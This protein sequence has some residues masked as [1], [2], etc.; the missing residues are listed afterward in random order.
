M[1]K[2][3]LWDRSVL[4]VE[5]N[6]EDALYQKMAT[7]ERFRLKHLA[8]PKGDAL[9]GKSIARITRANYQEYAHLL[10][11]QTSKLLAAPSNE[12]TDEQRQANLKKLAKMKAEFLERRAQ[13]KAERA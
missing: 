8:N 3:T 4:Y 10:P 11:R 7:T 13:R 12:I 5:D 2:V 1:L 6:F 9:V